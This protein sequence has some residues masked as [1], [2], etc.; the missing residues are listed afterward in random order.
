MDFVFHKKGEFIEDLS[1]LQRLKDCCV[2]LFILQS[3]KLT[4]LNVFNHSFTSFRPKEVFSR[5]YFSKCLIFIFCF[6][7]IISCT[8]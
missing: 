2:K 4:V 6:N 8:V 7:G 5:Y 1:D 3:M